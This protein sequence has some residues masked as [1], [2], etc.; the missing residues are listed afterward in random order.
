VQS[1]RGQEAKVLRTTA[2]WQGVFGMILFSGPVL[3]A[4]ACFGAWTLAGNELTNARA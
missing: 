4:I 1:A 2:A 3:V